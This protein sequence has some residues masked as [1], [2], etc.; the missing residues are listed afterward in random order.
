MR[1]LDLDDRYSLIKYIN[2]DCISSYKMKANM[3]RID[4]QFFKP[5]A[6]YLEEAELS[7]Q[8]ITQIFQAAHKEAQ[9]SGANSTMLGKVVEKI[10]PDSLLQKLSDSLP[11]PDPNA[12]NDPQFANKANAAVN[13]LPVDAET[14]GGLLKMVANAA[15]N[16][17]VQPVVLALVGGVL[18]GMIQKVG[19]MMNTMGLPGTLV[20]GVSGAL[21]AGGVA[22]A[23]AK[24]S[25]KSWKESFKSA[26][27]PALAGAAGAV[28]GKLAADF[29]SGIGSGDSAKAAS[30]ATDSDMQKGLAA[31]QAMQDRLLNKYPPDQGYTFGA[32]G[33]SIEVYDA[34]GKKVF[35]GDIPLKTMD[36]QTFADLTSQGK[37]ATPGISSGSA[38]SDPMAGVRSSP[39]MNIQ[40]DAPVGRINWDR[41]AAGANPASTREFSGTMV[42]NEP[43]VPGQPLSAQQMAVVDMGKSMGNT[44]SPEVQAAYDLA[45][46][47]NT[48]TVAPADAA[49][50]QPRFRP[51]YKPQMQIDPNYVPQDTNA[52]VPSPTTDPNTG[53][54]YTPRKKV[55]QSRQYLG[56]KLT[57]GQCYLVMKQVAVTNRDMIVEGQLV[58][59]AGMLQKAGTWLKTK[60]QNVTQQVT[61]DK[62]MTAWKKAGSPM[63]SNAVA[64]I[65]TQ[66]GVNPEVIKKVYT[67]MQLPEP[68]KEG[69]AD[70]ALEPVEKWVYTNPTTG[71]KYDAGTTK[72][73]KLVINFDGEWD[74]VEDESEI[75]AIMAAKGGDQAAAQDFDTV[76][77]QI[78]KLPVD[79][80]VQLVNYMKNE[81]KVA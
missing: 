22:L 61:A 35:T 19:P 28:V 80:K 71:T 1:L 56:N 49:Q 7:Q 9:A 24:I 63:D 68:G 67:G 25:G 74:T 5:W 39:N 75:K 11:E 62:L 6:R 79:S 20:A 10:V 54:V 70:A 45:K 78:L 46:Q 21:V 51:R 37:M 32:R 41:E 26:V 34:S 48:D 27:K 4:E 73:G 33:D 36:A 57:E 14:K 53:T 60:A 3:E 12:A 38:S 23:A 47:S 8:Q 42:A 69:T 66:A 44:P 55:F 50:E 30:G 59:E 43:V 18:G 15:K 81:L 65:M 58:L 40:G 77:A 13:K 64:D 72:D 31:D 52:P 16:P 29:V 76:K 17:A 2:E